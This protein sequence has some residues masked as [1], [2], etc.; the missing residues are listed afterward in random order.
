MKISTFYRNVGKFIDECI[1]KNPDSILYENSGDGVYFVKDRNRAYYAYFLPNYALTAVDDSH[2]VDFLSKACKATAY[3]AD[4]MVVGT[5]IVTGKKT[6][7]I[8]NN[9][10][11]V[12]FFN[13]TFINKFPDNADFYL[14][15]AYE[16]A[17]VGIWDKKE[18][19]LHICGC[20]CP[21]AINDSQFVE[22]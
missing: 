2:A 5:N 16:P 14:K 12:Q 19:R 11:V 15:G 9:N 21:L 1:E 17:V 20:I 18:A 10:G 6:V 8:S 22:D 3:L 13:K 4:K 7:R